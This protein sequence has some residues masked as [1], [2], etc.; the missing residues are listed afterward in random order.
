MATRASEPQFSNSNRLLV[1]L[2]DLVDLE[3]LLLDRVANHL[4]CHRNLAAG[5]MPGFP[6]KRLFVSFFFA[7]K[8]SF[9]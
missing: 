1:D 3:L 2:V 7:L 8:I 4:Q 5:C 9:A 6:P